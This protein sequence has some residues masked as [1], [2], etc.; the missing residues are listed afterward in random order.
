MPPKSPSVPPRDNLVRAVYP[1]VELRS[2]EDDGPPVL[3]GHFT[4]YNEWTEI[5]SVYE[6]RFMERFAPG[7]FTKTISENFS[8]IRALFQHGQDPVIGDK[9]LGPIESLEEDEEGVRYR[10]PLLDTTYNSELIPGLKA[11]LYGSSHRFSVVK[12]SLNSKAKRSAHNPEGL[13]ERTVTEARLFEFGPVTFPAYAGATAGVRSMTDA[14]TM[15][16]L[17]SDP[18]RLAELLDSMRAEALPGA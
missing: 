11:G 14:Y 1:A 15:R 3:E 13:P 18:Q 17:A 8:R 4:K 5:D 6:G 7:A 9:P 16:K 2:N 12:E 10:V